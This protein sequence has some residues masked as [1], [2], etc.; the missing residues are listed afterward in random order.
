[1][2]ETFAWSQTHRTN[3]NPYD[4][5]IVLSQ[6]TINDE[7]YNMWAVAPDDSP[8][9]SYSLHL[10]DGQTLD[11]QL[12][13]PVISLQVNNQESVQLYYYLKMLSGTLKLYVSNDPADLTMKSFDTTDWSIAVPVKI[14]EL[15][16]VSNSLV[17]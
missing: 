8:L 1:M 11:C 14:C 12:D 16:F 4:Q 7:L 6:K 17:N 13:A 2:G 10:R 9:L 5:I 15:S 3:P